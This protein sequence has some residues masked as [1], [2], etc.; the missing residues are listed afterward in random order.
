MCAVRACGSR[1]CSAGPTRAAGT[2]ISHTPLEPSDAHRVRAA[3]PAVEVA[4]D[5]DALRVR[6]PDREVH[7]VG[8]A[9]AH[10]VRA[11]LVVDAGVVALAEQI[12]IEVGDDA[13]VPIRVVDLRPRSPPG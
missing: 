11:E 9:D 12:E 8:V 5:A 13:A 10:R 7:A 3:V 2:K 1:T 4:D 6:R